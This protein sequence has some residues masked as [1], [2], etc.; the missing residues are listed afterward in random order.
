M[1]EQNV[2]PESAISEDIQEE[3]A[4]AESEAPEAVPQAE[5]SEA[6]TENA[7]EEENTPEEETTEEPRGG[8]TVNFE[9]EQISLT[10]E[11]A[12][13]YAE[14]GMF[15]QKHDMK[16]L[17]NRLDYL[18]SLSDKNVKDFVDDLVTQS[19]EA[20]KRMLIDRYG[21]DEEVISA[22]LD[23][24]HTQSKDKYEKI[25]AARNNESKAARESNETRLANEFVELQKEFPEL[26]DFSKLPKAVK[27][28]AADGESLM[29]AYLYHL[30][31][32]N[33]TKT[34]AKNNQS[35]AANASAGSLNDNT[36]GEDTAVSAFLSG[37]SR[38]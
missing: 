27:K 18:A 3:T 21:D 12:K 20:Y 13:D 7:H 28:A 29:S 17:Y 36:V 1:E 23:R 5:G 22:M 4:L 30:H 34:A 16:N 24:Y 25:V 32:I 33:K 14:M 26:S 6:E 11:Q 9:H 31:T 35:K 15:L 10:P 37:L 8:I 2:N 38:V 19:D